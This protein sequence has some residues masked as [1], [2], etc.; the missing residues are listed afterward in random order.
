M[1]DRR[2]LKVKYREFESVGPALLLGGSR[3]K[4]ISSADRSRIVPAGAAR[5]EPP[6]PAKPEYDPDGLPKSI[7]PGDQISIF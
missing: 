3:D 6:F 5:P 7:V 1:T 2:L 4:M